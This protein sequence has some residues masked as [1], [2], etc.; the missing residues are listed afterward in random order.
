MGRESVLPGVQND[1]HSLCHES[2][3]C[4]AGVVSYDMACGC[5]FVLEADGEQ[6][7]AEREEL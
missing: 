5:L 1:S 2:L 4:R 7:S 3:P 6:A